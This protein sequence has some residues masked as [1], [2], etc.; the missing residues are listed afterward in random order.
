MPNQQYSVVATVCRNALHLTNPYVDR[1]RV[2]SEKGERVTGTCEWIR[3]NDTYKSWLDGNTSPLWISGGPGKGKTMLSIFLTEELESISQRMEDTV[4]LFFFC[5]NK[6]EKRNTVVAILAGLLH[7][8]VEKR[9]DL[10]NRHIWPYFETPQICQNT[11]SSLET[12]WIVL[13]NL[14]QDPNLGTIFCVLDGLDECDDSSSRALIAKLVSF[15]LQHSQ[16]TGRALRL[17]IV[18]RNLVGLEQCARVKLDPD[19]NE[20]EINDVER[21][22][23]FGINNL[24]RIPGFDGVFR[25]HVQNT[26]LERA[27]G[28]FLWAGFV[29]NELSHKK[30]CLDVKETLEAIPPGLPAIYSRILLKIEESRRAASIRILH[31]VTMAFH[32]LTLRELAVAID[33][34]PSVHF[35]VE[36]AVRDHISFCGPFLKVH[37]NRVSLIHQSARDYLLREEVDQNQVMENFRIKPEE[38]HLALAREGLNHIS[39]IYLS[40]E[41][42]RW[43]YAFFHWPKHAKKR[44]MQ[45]AK[46]LDLSSPFFSDK[47]GLWRSWNEY[48]FF[49][50]QIRAHSN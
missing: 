43:H 29:M 38:A 11:M 47:S 2:K 49:F 41:S 19:N 9:P 26:L 5:D 39:N 23:S 40:G 10:I 22:I 31:W 14:L 36:Q 48:Y 21:F 3:N 28:T 44:G 18:S 15:S 12:L 4:V 34:Q 13:R 7:Q 50:G 1:E 45:S 17:A 25:T 42:P 33:V 8:I 6:D 24:S 16:S 37:K 20:R 27:D 32:P 30:T 35:S 46:L